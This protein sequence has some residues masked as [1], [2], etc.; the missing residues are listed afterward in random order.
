MVKKG[1][2]P[3]IDQGVLPDIIQ[4]DLHERAAVGRLMGERALGYLGA[5]LLFVGELT[6][7]DLQ[8]VEVPNLRS[9]LYDQNTGRQVSGLAVNETE[10]IYMVRHPG[11]FTE[12]AKAGTDHAR[13]IDPIP[14]RREAAAERSVVHS[15]KGKEPRSKGIMDWL[16]EES[17]RLKLLRREITTPHLSHM[18]DAELRLLGNS[19]WQFSIGNTLAVVGHQKD[20]DAEKLKTAERAVLEKMVHGPQKNRRDYWIDLTNLNI[21]YNRQKHQLF[22]TKMTQAKD[23]AR[24]AQIRADRSE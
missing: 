18:S 24:R 7:E 2:N 17:K 4:V 23:R 12:A 20:W 14:R 22:A 1:I 6:D 13:L 9:G 3:G 5:E 10:Y 16:Q 19:V 11:A 21:D 8:A 15:V